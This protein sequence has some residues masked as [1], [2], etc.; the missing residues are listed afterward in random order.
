M[1]SYDACGHRRSKNRAD[2]EIASRGERGEILKQHGS[3]GGWENA[4]S[5]ALEAMTV[6]VQCMAFGRLG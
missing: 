5:G 1:E 6:K 2:F 4:R 3:H